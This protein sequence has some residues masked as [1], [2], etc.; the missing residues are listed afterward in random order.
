MQRFFL[1]DVSL[2]PDQLC[3]L[4]SLLHQLHRVLRAQPGQHICL[5]DG[6]GNE[7]LTELREISRNHATGL[8]LEQRAVEGEPNVHLTLYQCALKADKLEW[9]LQKGTE[10]G[11]SRFVPVIS[12]RTIVRPANALLKK[13]ARW[14][15]ILREAAEQCGRGRLPELAPPL[16]WNEV[17]EEANGLRFLPWEE[18]QSATGLVTALATA[19]REGD[20]A[21]GRVSLLVGPE[22]GLA[23]KEVVAAQLAGWQVVTLGR[24]IL[25][26]ET[27]AIVAVS[28]TMAQYGELG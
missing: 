18:G 24:R 14:Q 8:V 12:Q 9:V 28:L 15:D 20:V 25:R 26:A 5:L 22:G 27:A 19:Q 3:D 7:F 23:V 17:V 4:R 1:T 2:Q 16:F 11:V 13:Y 6:R 10:L 21:E